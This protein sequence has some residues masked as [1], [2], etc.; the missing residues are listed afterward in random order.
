MQPIQ[1]K[2]RCFGGMQCRCPGAFSVGCLIAGHVVL[3][4]K[5]QMDGVA[6]ELPV[7][8]IGAPAAEGHVRCGVVIRVFQPEDIVAREVLVEDWLVNV[9][10]GADDTLEVLLV[11][12][13]VSDIV[14]VLA[15]VE[16]K[17]NT[18]AA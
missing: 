15:A 9:L 12:T 1:Y 18:V 17:T 10:V 8:K 3:C 11:A 5:V 13:A 6:Y 4:A 7:D 16:E 14:E 2:D